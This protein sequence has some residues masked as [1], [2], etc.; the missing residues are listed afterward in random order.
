M[1]QNKAGGFV[2]WVIGT[3]PPALFARFPHGCS[4]GQ[5]A[6]TFIPR[7]RIPIVGLPKTGVF[8]VHCPWGKSAG[9][10]WIRQ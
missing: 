2:P 7:Y 4:A 5:K 10:Y 6:I 8:V 1:Q 9:N 3:K